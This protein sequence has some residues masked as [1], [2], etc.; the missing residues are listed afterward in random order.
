[1]DDVD[2]LKRMITDLGNI[3]D[4]TANQDRTTWDVMTPGGS[5]KVMHA[6]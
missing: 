1:M 2:P 5:H 6:W 4:L 3:Y